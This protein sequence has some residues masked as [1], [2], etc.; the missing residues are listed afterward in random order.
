MKTKVFLISI[1]LA[2]ILIISA[3]S[4]IAGAASLPA[5][6]VISAKLKSLKKQIEAQQATYTVG[7]SP[8]M[9]KKIGQL[10]GMKEPAGWAD[11]ARRVEA[12][13]VQAAA[14]LPSSYDWR[15]LGG[16]TP[17]KD[18]GNCGSC[19]AFATV[20]PLESQIKL[21]CGSTVDLSEQYLVSCNL[22]G[23][24]C[25][26][27]WWAHDYHLDTA[28]SGEQP[29]AVLESAFP[30]VA[31]DASCG[32]SHQHP[33]KISNWTYISGQPTPSVQ[34]IKQAVHTYGPV[35][36]G[37]VVGTRFQAYSSGIFNTSESGV[38]TTQ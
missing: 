1:A 9:R 30:Y 13:R 23:W 14:G 19:W 34:A 3:T 8:A 2:L 29:G 18:Q 22:D 7:D 4:I 37:L 38:S 5:D 10:C 20:A 25:S 32:S 36:V 28:R 27:G 15:T 11:H 33:Y 17:V 12:P 31:K 26:G 35:S 6:P 21:Q 24:G 16:T